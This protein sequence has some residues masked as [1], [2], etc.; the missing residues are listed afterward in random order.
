MDILYRKIRENYGLSKVGMSKVLGFGVNQW[1]LYED[2]I[3]KPDRSSELLIR[4]VKDPRS[5]LALLRIHERDLVN[6][7]KGLGEKKYVRLVARTKEVLSGY[8]VKESENYQ[9]WVDGLYK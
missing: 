5:M 7:K 6:E 9:V 2:G 8:D 1:R 3:N 4:V